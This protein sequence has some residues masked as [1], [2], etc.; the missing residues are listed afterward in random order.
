ME[1]Q[2]DRYGNPES[3]QGRHALNEGKSRRYRYA[4]RNL[5][6]CETCDA[7]IV[8]YGDHPTHLQFVETLKQAH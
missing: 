3:D 5:A 6:E 2:V 7:A 1:S 4:A 8:D